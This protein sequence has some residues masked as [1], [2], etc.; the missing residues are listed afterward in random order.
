MAPSQQ[1]QQQQRKLTHDLRFALVKTFQIIIMSSNVIIA[2]R[3]VFISARSGKMEQ[4]SK[5]VLT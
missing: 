4:Q 1:Q 2:L 3:F 5:V